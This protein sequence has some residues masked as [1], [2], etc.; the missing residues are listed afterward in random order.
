MFS[1]GLFSNRWLIAGVLTMVALQMFFTYNSSMNRFF[2]SAPIAP[3]AW[4]RIFLIGL[5]IHIIIEI[6][7]KVRVYLLNRK[8]A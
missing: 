6:E 3:D 5:L 8:R 7:K 1:L 4:A 2:H